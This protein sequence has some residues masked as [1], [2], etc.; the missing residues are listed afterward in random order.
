MDATHY[1][2]VDVIHL[3]SDCRSRFIRFQ[4]KS[5]VRTSGCSAILKHQFV[6]I[7]FKLDRISAAPSLFTVDA[8]SKIIA[9][10][11]YLRALGSIKLVRIMIACTRRI[12]H[13]CSDGCSSCQ[14]A[15]LVSKTIETKMDCVIGWTEKQNGSS[16]VSARV[17]YRRPTISSQFILK[18]SCYL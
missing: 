11:L 12:T 7:C 13:Y 16:C 1:E 17:L 9:N 5:M 8:A 15:P 10:S 14:A 18:V 6:L 3:F 4:R 2:S